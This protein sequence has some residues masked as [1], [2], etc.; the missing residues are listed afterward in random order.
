M[1]TLFQ[2][3]IDYLKDN[4]EGYWFKRKLYGWGWTPAT[5]EGWAVT[6]VFIL[7]VIGNVIRFSPETKSE[8]DILFGLMPQTI[9]LIVIFILIVVLKGEPPK[10]QW[11]L[12]KKKD[13]NNPF[14]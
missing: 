10:W 13:P 7:L 9:V 3:Y 1:R 14:E 4:P 8:E 5:R 11:G 2:K 6:A 12:P